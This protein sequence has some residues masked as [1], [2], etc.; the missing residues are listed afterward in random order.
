MGRGRVGGVGHRVACM[1]AS[2][3]Q[4]VQQQTGKCPDEQKGSAGVQRHRCCF[5]GGMAASANR[6]RPDLTPLQGFQT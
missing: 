2:P 5:A 3:A 1:Q 4:E 6:P